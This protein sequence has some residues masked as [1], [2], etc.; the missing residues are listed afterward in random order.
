LTTNVDEWDRLHDWAVRENDDSFSYGGDEPHRIEADLLAPHRLRFLCP[1]GRRSR[2]DLNGHTISTIEIEG[3]HDAGIYLVGP[4][5]VESFAPRVNGE[6]QVVV[7]GGLTVQR[8]ESSTSGVELRVQPQCDVQRVEV[9]TGGIRIL[10]VVRELVAGDERLV[11]NDEATARRLTSAQ[12]VELMSGR[13]AVSELNADRVELCSDSA[14]VVRGEVAHLTVCLADTGCV[15]TVEGPDAHLQSARVEGQGGE[16][17]VGG[18]RV[19]GL[20]VDTDQPARLLLIGGE[21]SRVSG[22]IEVSFDGPAGTVVGT[23][24]ATMTLHAVAPN[25][26]GVIEAVNFFAASPSL[27]TSLGG[28]RRVTAAWNGSRQELRRLAAEYTAGVR[29][30]DDRASARAHYWASVERLLEEKSAGGQD[31]SIAHELAQDSRRLAAPRWSVDALLLRVS[32]LFGYSARIVRPLLVWAIAALVLGVVIVGISPKAIC[33]SPANGAPPQCST[34]RAEAVVWHVL[35][36]PVTWVRPLG[37][38]SELAALSERQLNVETIAFGARVFG[39]ISL[40]SLALAVRRRL[41]PG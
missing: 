23:P 38:K 37:D 4:G 35:V 27:V 39:T 5:R 40:A 7:E 26:E 25:S 36:S 29:S 13:L 18:G 20:D 14:L 11:V 3:A 22:A 21:V 10:G 33:E 41:R 15:L 2:L 6:V 1:N 30:D 17:R 28:L 8:V 9:M 12:R 24:E 32:Q 31:L 19:T 34:V 16:L